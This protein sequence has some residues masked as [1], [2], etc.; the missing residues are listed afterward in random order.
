MAEAAETEAEVQGSD[1]A[2][3]APES[4]DV[5]VNQS[6][7]GEVRDTDQ[8]KAIEAGM[9]RDPDKRGTYYRHLSATKM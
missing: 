7:S 9:K 6:E 3:L 2:G 8:S 4:G 5:I 1:V